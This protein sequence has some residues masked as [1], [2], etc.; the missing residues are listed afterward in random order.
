MY[1]VQRNFEG[2]FFNIQRD[3]ETVELCFTD[4]TADEQQELLAK[5]EP[6][7]VADLCVLLAKNLRTLLDLFKLSWGDEE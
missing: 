5:L 3:G 6:N 2:E 1:P 4:M 7:K